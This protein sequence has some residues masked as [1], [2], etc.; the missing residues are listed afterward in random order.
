MN[1][2]VIAYVLLVM[3]PVLFTLLAV[4]FWK[5]ALYNNSIFF[6]KEAENA[7]LFVI[8]PPVGFMY[9]IFASIAVNS[10]F[11]KF[12]IISQSVTTKDQATY[13]K[14]RDHRLPALMHLL[15]GV[16]SA[17][18]VALAMLYQYPD[19]YAGAASVASVVFVIAITWTIIVAFDKHHQK[20]HGLKSVPVKWRGVEAHDF[21]TE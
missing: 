9:V 16:P 20:P 21:F 7:I 10:V 18:L 8:I 12:K 11:D 4:L 3:K 2:G 19:L 5:Y 13:M 6:S 15:V 14:H 1:K 17:I